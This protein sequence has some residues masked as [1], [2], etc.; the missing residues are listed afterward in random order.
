M[1]GFLLTNI[2]KLIIQIYC[3][4]FNINILN[5][6]QMDP[7]NYIEIIPNEILCMI[8]A[9]LPAHY[10]YIFV[11]MVCKDLAEQLAGLIHGDDKTTQKLCAN[12]CSKMVI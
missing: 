10:L 5:I 2:K 1:H 8:A 3:I 4:M 7:I 6:I 11:K 12:C 9:Y